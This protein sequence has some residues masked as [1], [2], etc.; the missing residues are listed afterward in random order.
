MNPNGRVPVLELE[1]SSF[2]PESDAILFYLAEGTPFFP[3]ERL[4]G[5]QVLSWMFFEQYSHEPNIATLR[6]WI[7]HNVSMSEERRAGRV[8]LDGQVAVSS[9]R[10]S[11]PTE[12][13]HGVSYPA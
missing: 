4:G 1:D 8:V 2:L 11:L 9:R 5:A 3:D 13:G 7:T 6:Y 10:A 12:L